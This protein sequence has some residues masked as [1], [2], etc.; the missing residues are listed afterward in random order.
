MDAAFPERFRTME[1][2]ACHELA[3]GDDREVFTTINLDELELAQFR[4]LVPVKVLRKSIERVSLA[5][6]RHSKG[7]RDAYPPVRYGNLIDNG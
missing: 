7:F 4:L 5:I 1:Q 2:V 6:T 3:I